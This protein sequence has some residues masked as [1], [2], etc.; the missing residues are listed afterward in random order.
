MK[1]ETETIK[2]FYILYENKF[3]VIGL[4]FYVIIIKW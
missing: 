4:P 2:G 1:I 3:I